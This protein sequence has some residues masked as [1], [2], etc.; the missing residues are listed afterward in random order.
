V[1]TQ[2]GPGLRHRAENLAQRGEILEVALVPQTVCEVRV[3]AVPVRPLPADES[4]FETTWAA[5]GRGEVFRE[6]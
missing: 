1:E 5:F 2:H 3:T 6:G 4:W